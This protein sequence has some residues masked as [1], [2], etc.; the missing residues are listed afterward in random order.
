MLGLKWGAAP[1]EVRLRLGLAPLEVGPDLM[2]FDLKELVD[3][4]VARGA[5]CPSRF[6]DLAETCEG[7]LHLAFTAAGLEA[8]ELRFRYAF[9]AI[10]KSADGLS[11]LAMAAYARA[12]LAQQIFEFTARYGPPVHSN[13][14][15]MR[16]ENTHP[17]GAAVF[18]TL[19]CETVQI[20][21]GHDGG[22]VT[23]TIRYLPPV[24]ANAGF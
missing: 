4:L 16:W 9:E 3:R 20:M 10:G 2:I 15:P 5:F 11:D 13:E 12:E 23:G 6:V 14:Q 1:E 19:E 21:L 7:R 24:T 18:Q 17:V 22:G 8:G